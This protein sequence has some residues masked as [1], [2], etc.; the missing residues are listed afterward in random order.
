M[1]GKND[2]RSLKQFGTKELKFKQD[3]HMDAAYKGH[4][5]SAP[6]YNEVKGGVCAALTLEWLK[7]K[8]SEGKYHGAFN[9]TPNVPAPKNLIHQGAIWHAGAVSNLLPKQY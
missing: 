4:V 3:V 1:A 8:L 7:A 5:L 6:I 9:P 2:F